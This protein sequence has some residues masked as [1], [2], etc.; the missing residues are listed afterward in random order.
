MPSMIQHKKNDEIA[1]QCDEFLRLNSAW[2]RIMWRLPMTL[3]FD[4]KLS[5]GFG[6]FSFLV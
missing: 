5:T 4:S 3:E 6:Q 1:I 2:F